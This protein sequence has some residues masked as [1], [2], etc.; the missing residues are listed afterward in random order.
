MVT[1]RDRLRPYVSGLAVQW[2]ESTPGLRHKQVV[3]SLAFVDI[4]GF[5]TLTERLAAKGKVGAEEMSDLLNMAFAELL[6]RA[7]R[8]GA[9]LVK[10]G[11][12][13]VL[14]LF[15]DDE[16]A[17]LACRAADE[18]R[19]TMRQ[20]GRLRTSV[21]V[22]QLKMS[23]GINSGAFDFFL[24][25]DQHHELLVAGPAAT[26]T[27]VMEQTAE[28]GEIVVSS[29]SAALLPPGC[30]GAAK[31]DG[32]LL[33]K[34]PVVAA[35]SRYWAPGAD[36][37]DPGTCLDPAIRDHLLTEV[38]ES[39]HRQVAVGFVEVS[40]VDQLLTGHGP[41]AVAA[42][43]HDLM[44]I[45][46]EECAH[47][48]VTFWETDISADG[49][50]IMLVA[51]AP[52]STGHDEEGLLRA[53]RNILD[54]YDGTARVRIGANSGRVFNGGF[55]PAFRRTWS[56]KGDAVNLAA[57]VMGKAQPGQLLA[58]EQLLRRVS[59]TVTA[60]LLPPF[61]VKGKKHQIHAAVVQA[62][63]L[64]RAALAAPSS[65]F[66]GR[67]DEMDAL[68]S[69]QRAAAAGR[70]GLVAVVGEPG[71][72]KSRLVDHAC[73]RF[74][75]GTTILRGFADAYESATPYF[76]VRRLLR[77]AIGLAPEA[78]DDDVVAA[79]RRQH[80]V[81][82]Q[83][84]PLLARPF[85]VALDD[86]PESAE[87]R[88]EFRRAKT[89]SLVIELLAATLTSPTALVVDDVQDADDASAE[90]LARI[91]AEAATRP[92]LLIAA[93][94]ALPAGLS[95]VEPMERIE[96]GGLAPDE[97]RDLALDTPG[98]ETLTP[99][100]LR[101]VLERGEGNPLF[102]R[103][104]T[105]A[106]AASHSDEL[107]TSL[108]DLLSA[109]VDDLAPGARR[110]LRAVS[111]LG[112]RFEPALAADLLGEQPE[113]ADWQALDRFLASHPDG[114][115]RFRT[116]LA[117]DAAY[118]GLPYRRR[119]ELHGRAAT[120]LQT[121]AAGREEDVVEALSLHCLAAQ[122]YDDAWRYSR[123]AGD[124]AKWMYANVDAL[125]SYR[126][127]REAARHLHGLSHDDVAELSETI[128]DLHAR[129]AELDAATAAYREAR[130]VASSGAYALRARVA[131]RAAVAATRGGHPQG[132]QR[133]LAK[134]DA[135]LDRAAADGLDDPAL[136]E[137]DARATVER[138]FLL[139]RQ[140][141]YG[142]AIALGGSG[143]AKAEAVSAPL[144]VAKAL[145]VLDVAA[146]ATGHPGDDAG[147]SRALQLA[148]EAA[149]L[150]TQ[151]LM[152]KQLGVHAYY[153]GEWTVAAARYEGARESYERAGDDWNALGAAINVGE[154]LVDQ[155]RL[156]AAEP[157]VA[158]PLRAWRASGTPWDV[159][160][161]AALLGRLRARNGQYAE[162]VE[163]FTEAIAAYQ[164]SNYRFDAIEAELGIVEAFVLQ[165]LTADAL[166]RLNQ[167]ERE[168]VAAA[169]AAGMTASAASAD[170]PETVPHLAAF[171]RLQGYA[172]AQR[173][174][175]DVAGACFGMSLS[176]ARVRAS[177]LDIALADAA[178]V[179]L[180]PANSVARA[181]RD[182]LFAQ[183]D[184]V[185]VPTMPPTAV[186]PAAV[187]LV[188][189]PPQREPEEELVPGLRSR[190]GGGRPPAG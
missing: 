83:W 41:D 180:S 128:G 65:A 9:S 166:D 188:G 143:L 127:A 99:H 2:L 11:G 160:F 116:S 63:S 102:L 125:T 44:A 185:W 90:L 89:A 6:E 47:H 156:A 98:G 121:R 105:A 103:E 111:V 39:E 190:R 181:E 186:G 133:W 85:D 95:D 32:F 22:V 8:Y 45:V 54:R 15:E 4:S 16:H 20:V 150:P 136:Q 64:N 48:R 19:S 7:Y 141:R 27:A 26:A 94:R 50:K 62:V 120:A 157:L 57:R 14:L 56:V 145:W 142:E 140:G 110:L 92:W 130:R 107:P 118:E 170:L 152:Q 18:M 135:E 124:R 163:L 146:M 100:V 35:R 77:A 119:I 167:V 179:W 158:E 3:G 23:V 29:A 68:M 17:A 172:R 154:I 88:D 55:G 71:V 52:R 87:V 112:V 91:A 173:G 161:A 81:E 30:A 53:T 189:V 67:R 144:L 51:G 134:V 101:A 132:F 126:R 82:P 164:V 61:M 137:L 138:A 76:A 80:G 176:A 162:A 24:V 60:D 153:R 129:L 21:G 43:L 79:L 131:F 165:G 174:E 84:L 37:V 182:E 169:R 97:A 70:G 25:G 72:G 168:L 183:L 86:T 31:G 113:A 108:E 151:A 10:W 149:D 175:R 93:G 12:D 28:A 38:G 74:A 5:T 177:T 78:A 184:V 58:T 123:M 33:Q 139:F 106:M 75:D 49:F 36:P 69:A 148:E 34:A 155:G 104:L 73:S 42:T 147:I 66:V 96:L 109:Q 187:S 1:P 159:G 117:R 122:R 178:L 59:A 114:S 171:L 115:R 40:G 46:Q 13:A